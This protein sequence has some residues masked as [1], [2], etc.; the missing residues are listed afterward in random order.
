MNFFGKRLSEYVA[1][2][3]PFLRPGFMWERIF[4]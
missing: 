4:S 2:A 1:F 3:K